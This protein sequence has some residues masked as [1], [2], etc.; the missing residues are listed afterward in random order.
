M[1]FDSKLLSACL[2]ALC[3]VSFAE[4]FDGSL[5]EV[6]KSQYQITLPYEEILKQNVTQNSFNPKIR[7]AIE[8]TDISSK[9]LGPPYSQLLSKS[10]NNSLVFKGLDPKLPIFVNEV[11]STV[12]K[13]LWGTQTG[14]K[15]FVYTTLSYS[16]TQ[17]PGAKSLLTTYLLLDDALTSDEEVAMDA[18]RAKFGK[19]KAKQE[20]PAPDAL[21]KSKFSSSVEELMHS[22]Q[23]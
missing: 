1:I 18:Y 19:L 20:K 23:P 15:I 6:S 11:K 22:Q 8:L 21:V 7:F 3:S 13:R 5:S 9:P 4:N 2:L 12:I 17:K 16:W 10:T 14:A